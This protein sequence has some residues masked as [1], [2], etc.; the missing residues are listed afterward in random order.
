MI[1]ENPNLL[2][3][4]LRYEDIDMVKSNQI[5][6]IL[7]SKV[8]YIRGEISNLRIIHKLGSAYYAYLEQQK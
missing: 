3:P 7:L 1:N 2:F 4:V 5:G 6:S 8:E